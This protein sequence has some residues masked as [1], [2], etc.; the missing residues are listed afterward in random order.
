MGT[1]VVVG[2]QWGDEGKGKIVDLL[3][4]EADLVIRF[5][6]GDNA[7]HTVI[8]SFG[9][10]QLHLVPCGIFHPHATCLLGAGMVVN[11]ARLLEEIDGL[12]AHSVSTSGLR[13]S[14]RC[15]LIFPYH[16]LI[17]RLEEQLRGVYQAGT[18]MRGVGPAYTDKVRRLGI[19]AGDLLNDKVL[20]E[21]IKLVVEQN[22]Q[23]LAYLDPQRAPFEPDMLIESCQLWANRLGEKI[24]D[25]VELTQA[26]LDQGKRILLE[27]QLGVMRDID[28]GVYPF[29]TSSSPTAGGACVGA[30]IAPRHIERVIGVVKAYSTSV[31]GGPFVTELK[32]ADGDW[33][34]EAGQEYGATTGRPRR[35]GWFD[36]VAVRYAAFINGFSSIAVTKIDVLSS[37]P[38]IKICTAYRIDDQLYSL[39][40]VGKMLYAEPEPVYEEMPGWQ[41]DISGCRSFTALPPAAQ[42]YLL[43]L[44][45]LVHAKLGIVS[46]GPGREATFVVDS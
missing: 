3:S 23:L 18:T 31:G 1:T 41:E 35:C 40:P 7:G 22:N 9:K 26:F 44:S 12:E 38:T 24:V 13:I 36:A 27:G 16:V 14:Q 10:F 20:C 30:G 32:G 37:L 8:N 19:R 34:R 6:G 46:V 4:Q 39:P 5:Q 42:A 29:V 15:H 43:R 25:D 11:P 17:D 21:R 33:L 45:E 2:A 28:W